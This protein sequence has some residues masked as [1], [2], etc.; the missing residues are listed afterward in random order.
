MRYQLITFDD[1]HSPNSLSD[2][3]TNNDLMKFNMSDIAML[4]EEMG[5]LID[6]LSVVYVNGK[7]NVPH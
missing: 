3:I 6:N 2:A 1:I 7:K 4:R 5:K